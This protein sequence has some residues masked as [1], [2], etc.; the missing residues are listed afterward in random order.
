MGALCKQANH[1]NTTLRV[2]LY[3][4]GLDTTTS[5]SREGAP[6][7]TMQLARDWSVDL[8]VTMAPNTVAWFVFE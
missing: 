5:V 6:P 4:S 1:V 2:P 8:A 3:Y 7:V